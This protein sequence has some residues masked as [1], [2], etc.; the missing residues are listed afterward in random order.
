L[1]ASTDTLR[2]M[3]R[4]LLADRFKLKAHKEPQPVSVYALTALKPK[5]K[6]ADPSERST[7]KS[8]AVDGARDYTCQNTTMKQLA[9]KIRPTAGGYLDHPVVDRTGLTGSYDFTVTWAPAAVTR[10]GGPRGAAR[11]GGGGEA[12]STGSDPTGGLTVFQAVERQLGLK[13]APQ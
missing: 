1:V 10:G 11:E 9:A 12:V 7:C 6:E 4:A 3:V 2:T 5:M 8:G 13:L